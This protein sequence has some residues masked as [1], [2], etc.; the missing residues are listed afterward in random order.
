MVAIRSFRAGIVVVLDCGKPGEARNNLCPPA[1]RVEGV[2]HSDLR[3]AAGLASADDQ[4]TPGS[5]VSSRGSAP[6]S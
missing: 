5:A 2:A 3:D 4:P 6:R 1:S